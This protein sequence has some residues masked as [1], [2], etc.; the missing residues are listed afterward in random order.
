MKVPRL[1]AQRCGSFVTMAIAAAGASLCCEKAKPRQELSLSSSVV[2]GWGVLL[3]KA[4]LK[5]LLNFIMCT[6]QRFIRTFTEVHGHQHYLV[7]E[8]LHHLRKKL[9]TRQPRPTLSPIPAGLLIFFLF[10]KMPYWNEI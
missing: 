1:S 4:C 2:R 5:G 7:S 3:T 9:N 6:V 10:S 8:H